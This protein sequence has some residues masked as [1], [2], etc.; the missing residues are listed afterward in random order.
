MLTSIELHLELKTIN[1]LTVFFT[2]TFVPNIPKCCP[3]NFEHTFTYHIVLVSALLRNPKMNLH[4]RG[5]FNFLFLFQQLNKNFLA[6]SRLIHCITFFCSHDIESFSLET[7]RKVAT[8]DF[9]V[10]HYI[11]PIRKG[12]PNITHGILKQSLW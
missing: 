5:F 7:F 2:H 1:S 9:L 3:L 8:T 10:F 6:H 11:K 4:L 12:F